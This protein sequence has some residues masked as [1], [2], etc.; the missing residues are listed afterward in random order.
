MEAP[1][2]TA[3]H[4]PAWEHFLH[5]GDVGVRGFDMTPAEAFENAA[6]A[7]ADTGPAAIRVGVPAAADAMTIPGVVSPGMALARARGLRT[8]RPSSAA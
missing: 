1:E 2:R 3:V 7:V 4:P 8:A 5:E 6:R